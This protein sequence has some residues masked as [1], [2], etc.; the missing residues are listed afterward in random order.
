MDIRSSTNKQTDL[1]MSIPLNNSG[2]DCNLLFFLFIH[3]LDNLS[4]IPDSL[5]VDEKVVEELLEENGQVNQ[6]Y[7]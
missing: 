6:E 7:H 3:H 2:F 1:N 4:D 5:G